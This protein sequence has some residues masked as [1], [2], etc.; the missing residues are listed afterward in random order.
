MAESKARTVFFPY[1]YADQGLIVQLKECLVDGKPIEVVWS[2]DS[3]ECDLSAVAKWR[4][5]DLKFEVVPE[6]EAG[7]V[8]EFVPGPE[9]TDPPVVIMASMHCQKTFRRSRWVGALDVQARKGLVTVQLER[10][11][12]RGTADLTFFVVRTTAQDVDPQCA[13]DASARLM[14]S[15]VVTLR[16][17]EPAPHF[18]PGLKVEWESFSASKHR[19]RLQ[20]SKA[21]FHLDL[22]TR[23]E[24]IL[25]LN[26]DA[27]P[28]LCAV[29]K[30]QAPGGRRAAIRNSVFAGI[31]IPVWNCLLRAALAAV[32]QEDDEV[33]PG[34]EKNVLT[35]VAN[36]AEPDCEPAEAMR[37]L[38]KNMKRPEA[39]RSMEERLPVIFSE[40]VKMR[41]YAE[42]AAGVLR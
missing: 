40:L 10:A 35:Y 38:V 3:L 4:R 25:F 17:D 30:E 21:L 33:D 19:Y 41:E 5:A 12:L 32:S 7:W 22:D 29:L 36:V 8:P 1:L 15:R 42:A 34:W 14:G 20:H 37:R 9:R 16:I 31:A 11:S 18:G 24:P 27:D 39:Q 2:L 26:S 23:S 28:D 13:T 6:P